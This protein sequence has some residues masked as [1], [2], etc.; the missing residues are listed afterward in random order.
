[1]KKNPWDGAEHAKTYYAA[2]GELC[3][4]W[5]FVE[6]LY[7]HLASDMMSPSRKYHDIVF[8]HFG[9]VALQKFLEEYADATIKKEAHRK[10]I[11]YISK[12]ADRCRINRNLVV[13]AAIDRID[14]KST[15]TATLFADQKRPKKREFQIRLSD[16][17]R[18][19]N[20]CETVA[21]LMLRAQ[22]LSPRYQ[23]TIR[24]LGKRRRVLLAKPALPRILGESPRKSR[25]PKP[26]PRPSR[27]SRRKAAFS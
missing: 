27:A 20:Q 14:K 6:R 2:V 19:R 15:A 13:H 12:Y 4:I 7:S 3:S 17:L 1:M 26:P 9:F 5:S 22:G 8:R 21:M 18:I 24:T 11:A 16:I 10:H 23:N 25:K